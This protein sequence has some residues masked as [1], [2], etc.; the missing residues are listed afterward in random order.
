MIYIYCDESCHLEKDKSDVMVLGAIGIDSRYL[1]EIYED[2][3]QIKI[4][5][6]LDSWFEI[7]WTKVSKG[8]IDFYIELIKYFFNTPSLSFRG[9]VAT[10]KDE[11][12]HSIY[13]GNDYDTWYY[14]MYYLLLDPFTLPNNNYRIFIDI[15]DS[16][17][18]KKVKKLHEV[19]C[20]NKYD[21]NKE[22]I[23]DIKQ[24]H[25]HESEVLQL[26]DLFIGALSFFHRGLYLHSNS[27]VAKKAMI[28]K[29]KE[30][31]GWPLNHSTSRAESKFNLFIWQPRR[32]F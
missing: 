11:L 14:K 24:I 26:C 6:G 13:N 21:F 12:D 18:G 31:S 19:L 9:V 7:K 10:G 23:E 1:K 16:R 17:G 8:K 2:I 29:I 32:S 5:H 27:S 22:I 30:M 3:R 28:E 25:S 15:K 20:N 4:N